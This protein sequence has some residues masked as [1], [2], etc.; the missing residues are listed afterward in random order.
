M[1]DSS[2]PKQVAKQLGQVSEEVVKEIAKQPKEIIKEAGQQLGGGGPVPEE[3]PGVSQA[4]LAQQQLAQTKAADKTATQSRIKELEA[5]I[6][7]LRQQRAQ[8]MTARRQAALGAASEAGEKAASSGSTEEMK[9]GLKA[10]LGGAPVIKGRQ[11]RF[12][13]RGRPSQVKRAQ[14][15]AGAETVAR[16]IGGWE[17]KKLIKKWLGFTTL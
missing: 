5:E 3:K 15:K 13:G 8:Q 11:R 4:S 16:R 2:F 10:A 1:A 6:A 17:N 7:R 12:L 9:S 14:E